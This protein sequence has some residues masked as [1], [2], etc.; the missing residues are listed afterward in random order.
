MV[1][2]PL[3]PFRTPLAKTRLV[4]SKTEKVTEP[5]APTSSSTPAM[6]LKR[7]QPAGTW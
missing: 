6:L 5:R 7:V 4:P 1:R 3:L 2:L